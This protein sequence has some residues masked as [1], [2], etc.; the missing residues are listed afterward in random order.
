MCGSTAWQY[1][2]TNWKN[3]TCVH[4]HLANQKIQILREILKCFDPSGKNIPDDEMILYGDVKNVAI[5]IG[6]QQA[7]EWDRFWEAMGVKSADITVDQ[8]ISK[9][10]EKDLRLLQFEEFLE[11]ILGRQAAGDS[12]IP[13]WVYQKANSMKRKA[14]QSSLLAEAVNLLDESKSRVEFAMKCGVEEI[15]KSDYELLNRINS[16]LG[17]AKANT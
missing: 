4:C 16:F 5:I 8:A 10:K 13:L 12:D 14:F 9:W 3:V 7:A 6:K 15:R 2:T 17:W 11:T 1:A